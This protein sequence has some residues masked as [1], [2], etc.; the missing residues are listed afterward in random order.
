MCR[1]LIGC[2]EIKT[3]G[4]RRVLGA[5]IPMR[6]FAL[7]F[8]NRNSV[9]FSSCA[10]NKALETSRF[11]SYFGITA[12]YLIAVET[13]CDVIPTSPVRLPPEQS[14]TSRGGVDNA[15]CVLAG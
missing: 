9:Q 7:D 14:F 5:C 3:I 6:L 11:T 4:D 10:A 1:D 15:L 2:S 12:L 8:A 13:A